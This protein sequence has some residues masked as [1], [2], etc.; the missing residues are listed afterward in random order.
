MYFICSSNIVKGIHF[1]P[2]AQGL[3]L[4]LQLWPAVDLLVLLEDLSGQL[5]NEFIIFQSFGLDLY[6]LQ[7][8]VHSSCS[9]FILHKSFIL[10][11]ILCVELL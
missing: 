6:L 1:I 7:L 5:L 4:V 9:A 2:S 3:R 10:L 8:N 11:F